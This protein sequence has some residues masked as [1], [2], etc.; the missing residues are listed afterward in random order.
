M[1]KPEIQKIK[2][3][4][5]S[6]EAT[7]YPLCNEVELYCTELMDTIFVSKQDLLDMLKLFE[8]QEQE[9]K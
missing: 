2:L 5:G 4:K 6:Y 7:Y 8:E 1:S 3:S 9:N